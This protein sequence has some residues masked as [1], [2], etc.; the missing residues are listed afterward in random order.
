MKSTDVFPSYSN[1]FVLLVVLLNVLL[2]IP[3]R[4]KLVPYLH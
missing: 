2:L 1:I 4:M 3:N